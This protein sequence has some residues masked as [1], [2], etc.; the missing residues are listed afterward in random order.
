MA[1]R[2]NNRRWTAFAGLLLLVLGLVGFAGCGS[3][4]QTPETTLLG[5]GSVRLEGLGGGGSMRLRVSNP[6]PDPVRVEGLRLR[7]EVNGASFAKG[8]TPLETEIAPY[9]T[10]DVEVPVTLSNLSLLRGLAGAARSRRL[11]YDLRTTLTFSG[12]GEG[13]T[14]RSFSDTGSLEESAFG[15]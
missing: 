5:L 15:L 13:R 14:T 1:N 4:L 2:M 3:S 8:M 11:D 7:L 6:N 10:A 9:S 12:A